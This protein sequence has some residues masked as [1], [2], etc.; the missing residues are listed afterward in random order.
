MGPEGPQGERGEKGKGEAGQPGAQ[1]E[2]VSDSM[3]LDL[4]LFFLF[5]LKNILRS[6]C[7][8]LKPLFLLISTCLLKSFPFNVGLIDRFLFYASFAYNI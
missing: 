4:S 1:G 6:L 5:T 7:L 2:Q 3:V 8:S